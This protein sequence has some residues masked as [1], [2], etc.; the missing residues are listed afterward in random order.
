MPSDETESQIDLLNKKVLLRQRKRHT[1]RRVTSALSA[2]LFRGGGGWYPSPGRGI[3]HLWIGRGSTPAR[4]GAPPSRPGWDMPPI[5]RW[6]TPSPIQRWSTPLSGPG[7]GTPHLDL[8]GISPLPIQRW[9]ILPIRIWLGYLPAPTVQT[10][11]EYHPPGVN[12]LK[13]FPHPL[14]MRAVTIISERLLLFKT[15]KV[16]FKIKKL[17]FS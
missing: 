12:R 5:Q 17:S 14:G 2:V 6:G 3:P 8:T 11:L 16:N 13:T 1:G 7:W 15:L 10:R 9:G 4:D